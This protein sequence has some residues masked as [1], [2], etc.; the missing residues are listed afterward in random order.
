MN[1]P[2]KLY[3]NPAR[4]TELSEHKPYV[5]QYQLLGVDPEPYKSS[6]I[7]PHTPVILKG[8]PKEPLSTDNPRGRKVGMRNMPYAETT[9]SPI[10]RGKGPVP[11]VG[12]N[13]EHT[14]SSVDNEIIDD[15]SNLDI[16]QAHHMVDNN[17]YVSDEALGLENAYAFG[18]PVKI[19]SSDQEKDY[20]TEQDLKKIL[21]SKKEFSSLKELDDNHYMAIIFDKVLAVGPLDKVQAVVSS[22]VFGEHPEYQ[23]ASISIDDI[24][25]VKK[26]KLK[27]G[28]FLE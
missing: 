8:I 11:N 2:T 14:W 23:N 7:T 21:S 4:K 10:G 26:I 13:M 15:V 12:N 28:V 20:L 6:T 18:A 3:K 24:V 16:D 1:Q 9:S 22:L 17:D 25:V 5:P 19:E 27:V